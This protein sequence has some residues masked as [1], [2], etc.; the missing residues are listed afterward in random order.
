MM[1]RSSSPVR[2]TAQT[3]AKSKCRMHAVVY[4]HWGVQ[5]S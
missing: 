3:L 4:F 1:Q 5:P 2:T